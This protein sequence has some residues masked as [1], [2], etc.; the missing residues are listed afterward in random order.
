ME[1][2]YLV[3]VSGGRWAVSRTINRRSI[4]LIQDTPV[5]DEYNINIVLQS[6]G[7]ACTQQNLDRYFPMRHRIFPNRESGRAPT[8]EL[9]ELFSQLG[10]ESDGGCG[11]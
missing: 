11:I 7:I 8:L 2:R 5:D 10:R 1:V 6:L 9:L 4:A 3:P